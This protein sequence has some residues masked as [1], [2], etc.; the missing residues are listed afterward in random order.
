MSYIPRAAAREADP[1]PDE[2][3]LLSYDEESAKDVILFLIDAGARM[4]DTLVPAAAAEQTGM[5]IKREGE[6]Q[7]AQVSLLHRALEGAVSLMR[8]KLV[9]SPRDL[10][11]VMLYNTVS[12]WTAT[13]WGERRR[14]TRLLALAMREA[15]PRPDVSLASVSAP[16]LLPLMPAYPRQQETNMAQIGKTSMY[17]H[18]YMLEPI[19]MIDIANLAGIIDDLD[20]ASAWRA[21]SRAWRAALAYL[22]PAAA[23]QSRATTRRTCARASSHSTR[24][25]ASTMHGA[26]RSTPSSRRESSTSPLEATQRL[27]LHSAARRA[28]SASSSSHT[29]TTRTRARPTWR[30]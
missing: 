5:R 26:M 2:L 7:G 20:R 16:P 8:Q 28:A 9:A 27:T 22:L 12:A 25:C 19:G 15:V 10:V 21:A 23:T 14:C 17:E 4:H 1:D 13:L 24:R 18:T 3:E 30:A 11:G 29:P 6:A